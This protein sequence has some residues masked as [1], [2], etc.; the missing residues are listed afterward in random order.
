MKRFKCKRLIK[1]LGIALV[2]ATTLYGV[3]S[4]STADAGFLPQLKNNVCLAQYSGSHLTCTA[5]DIRVSEVKNVTNPDG[6]T[7]VECTDGEEFDFKADFTIVTTATSRYGY[8]I[9]LPEGK[10]SAKDESETNTC[11]VLSGSATELPG[12]DLD[13]DAC[14][15]ISKKAGNS[16]V[17]EYVGETITMLCRDDDNSDKADFNYCASWNQQEYG[18]CS[19]GAPTPAGSPS[20]CRCD[21][22]DI[23]VFIKPNPPTVIKTLTSQS[24][25]R[26]EPG[27]AF[28]YTVSFTNPNAQTSLFITSLTDE[29]DIGGEGTFDAS[30]N[31]WATPVAVNTNVEGQYLTSTN[32]SMPAN[33]GE[34]LPS[35]TYSCAFTVHI[36]DRDLPNDQSPQFYDDLVM[37]SLEDKNGTAVVDGDSCIDI[38]GSIE[39]DHCSNEITV[40]I[41]NLPPAIT[42]T[43]TANPN[44]VLEPGGNVEFTIEVKNDAEFW[45]SPLTLTTLS[46][47]VYGDLLAGDCG[48]LSTSIAENGTYTCKFTKAI[49]GNAGFKHMN[50]V[51]A[52]A[53][54]DEGDT[55]LGD[56]TEMVAVVDVASTISLVKTAV[57]K[58][59]SETGDD[60]SVYRDVDY[61]FMFTNTSTVDAVKFYKLDDVLLDANM[62]PIGTATDI[63]ADCDV[64]GTNLGNGIWLSAGDS[65]SCVI[66]MK[67]QGDAGG[68][69]INLATVYGVD[70][71]LVEREASDNETV[72]FTNLPPVTAM[73]FA[74]SKLM[75]LKIKNTG[76]EDVT[77]TDITIHGES[78]IDHLSPV[79]GHTLLNDGG[80]HEFVPYPACANGHTIGYSG[81]LND[82][83]FY[84]CAFTVELLPGI[85]SANAINYVTP[86][87]DGVTVLLEDNE[88][89]KVSHGINIE[90]NAVKN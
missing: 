65:A 4:L 37:L 81:S 42:V 25:T 71:D 67:L 17:H 89:S 21:T 46:D 61:T 74:S 84:E 58:S 13:G 34:I 3:T 63:T 79:P 43:K 5:N 55:A 86:A 77:L 23:D 53:K 76:I 10:W 82:N 7:P 19:A 2:S 48:A 73:T 78:V 40:Q 12:I 22:F 56:S 18:N 47:S 20:K 32:C 50:K 1:A 6:T 87:N 66:T 90:V 30:I 9:W 15:D 39:G 33:G 69:H 41:T 70:D 38:P 14:A 88:G 24:S 44:E 51:D 57:P 68:N 62:N 36:V 28:N 31:L 75:V 27:G 80:S 26:S 85:D 45:D 52:I 83:D 8:G 59:V 35:A 49:T 60:P 16:Q 29:I 11:S 72:T 54:D 64:N